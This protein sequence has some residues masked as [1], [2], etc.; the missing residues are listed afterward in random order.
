MLGPKVLGHQVPACRAQLTG[1][2]WTLGLGWGWGGTHTPCSS[3][4]PCKKR[5]L[6]TQAPVLEERGVCVS[7]CAR[8][9]AP[10]PGN[11]A[12]SSCPEAPEFLGAKGHTQAAAEA[13]QAGGP[14]SLEL[15][16]PAPHGCAARLAWPPHLSGPLAPRCPPC[17]HPREGPPQPCAG[18][19]RALRFVRS[20]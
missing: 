8:T 5:L 15:S 9:H 12:L 16:L 10:L 13:L 4:A 7:V 17:A 18:L 20:H 6:S 11:P 19:S 2:S 3:Q 14:L 1:E